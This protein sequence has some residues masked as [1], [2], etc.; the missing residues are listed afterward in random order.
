MRLEHLTGP[1]VGLDAMTAYAELLLGAVIGLVDTSVGLTSGFDR[2]SFVAQFIFM[3]F[4]LGTV[5][6][7]WYDRGGAVSTVTL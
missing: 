7:A 1:C 6:R 2:A 5:R 3:S 4:V